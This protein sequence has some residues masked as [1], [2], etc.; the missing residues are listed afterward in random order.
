MATDSPALTRPGLWPREIPR[1][2]ESEAEQKVYKALKTS[3]P[4]GWYAWHSLRLRTRGRGEFSE[5]DFII[6]DPN[7]PGIFILE[8]K[9]G[10]IE[11]RDGQ[12]YQNSVQLKSSPLD[13]AF[14][15]LKKLVRRF[16][17]EDTKAPTIGV[18][19]CYPDTFFDQQPAQDDLKGLVIGGQDIPYLDRIL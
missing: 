15:F 7:R 13:Q 14:S 3:L 8:V 19:L 9:G 16:K 17:E 18:A 12:W 4:G 1:H 10:Q 6:A 2:T 11:Q 5:A